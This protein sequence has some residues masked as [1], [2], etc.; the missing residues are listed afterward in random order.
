M[1]LYWKS[2]IYFC[3]LTIV[4]GGEKEWKMDI[5]LEKIF[6]DTLKLDKLNN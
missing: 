1:V 6:N 2:W 4:N 3:W 5:K